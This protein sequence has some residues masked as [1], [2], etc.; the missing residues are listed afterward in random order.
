MS[1]R[2]RVSLPSSSSQIASDAFKHAHT[3]ARLHDL[4]GLLAKNT[5][6][7]FDLK[8]ATRSYLDCDWIELYLGFWPL[9]HCQSWPECSSLPLYF[10]AVLWPCYCCLSQGGNWEVGYYCN[11][12]A[13]KQLSWLLHYFF[14][15][16]C[17]K[18]IPWHDGNVGS[19]LKLGSCCFC[20]HSNDLDW[21]HQCG[22][23]R[24]PV[25]TA[26]FFH[27]SLPNLQLP[28]FVQTSDM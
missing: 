18:N 27:E 6:V 21:Q 14:L 23:S 17:L 25:C 24:R 22:L 26:C 2:T 1:L 12:H 5:V 16:F 3:K 7:N 15:H 4:Q 19:C 9:M 11:L 20:R 13:L 8:C 28:S 10:L